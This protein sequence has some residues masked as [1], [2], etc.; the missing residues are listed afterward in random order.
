MNFE[1]NEEQ[2]LLA[3]SV[4]RFVEKDYD[5]EKRRKII[6]SPEGWDRATWTALAEM[7]VTALALPSEYGGFDGGAAELMPIMEIFG[8]ALLVEP[9][10]P[11][12]MASRLVLHAGSETQKNAILPRVVEGALCMA[13]AHSERG[14]RFNPA[15]VKVEAKSS[16]ANWTISGE[17]CAVVGAPM[18]ETLVVSART[19]SGLGLFLVDTK[20]AE[21][22]RHTTVDGMRAADI[23]LSNTKAELLS[24]GPNVLATIE[25]VIDFGTALV[26]A[27]AVGAMKYAVETTIDY[28]KT[29]K[30]FGVPLSSFQVLQH[31]M[32]DMYIAS[33]VSQSMTAMA[34]SKSDTEE[35]P[36][37][38][39][40]AVSAAKIKIS[41]SALLVS[42]DSAQLHGGMGL[43]EELKVSHTFR[44]LTVLMAQFGD[45]DYHLTRFAALD[46]QGQ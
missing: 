21:L 5:F 32:V 35:N 2:R 34:C 10:L 16:G 14:A 17:K 23:L 7:G 4:Q 38:R 46:P 24:A 6:A 45:V 28:T 18:A 37:A 12:M 8:K 27:E 22:K 44:R 33:E 11:T 15:H 36:K 19:P 42:Q 39:S 41:D 9:F 3:D 25:A 1:L 43:T 13:F 30:Q 29:R 31:R 40:R 26:C 20:D